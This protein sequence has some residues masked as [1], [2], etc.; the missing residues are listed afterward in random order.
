VYAILAL[1]C[2]GAAAPYVKSAAPGNGFDAW[3][4]LCRKF[5][6]RS[7]IALLNR[8]LH[9]KFSSSDPRVNLAEWQR[10]VQDYEKISGDRVTDSTRRS[11]YM[12]QIAPEALRH[13]LHMNQSRLLTSDD[14]AEE[15]ESYIDAQ[16]EDEQA[17]SGTVGALSSHQEKNGG[18]SAGGKG[19]V[20]TRF[21]SEGEGK[22]E[23][24]KEGKGREKGKGKLHKGMGKNPERG[25]QR[26]FA[27]ACIWC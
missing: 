5:Q 12:T 3:K 1:T 10:E 21:E 18:K 23:K 24:G 2:K 4:K 19:N 20:K 16:E 9:P 17:M 11:I 14:I 26:K 27:G 7:Q 13:H 6:V 8:L 25:E 22:G 15:I